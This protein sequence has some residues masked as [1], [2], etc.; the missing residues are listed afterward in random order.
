MGI[1]Y[2]EAS[3]FHDNSTVYGFCYDLV[4]DRPVRIRGRFS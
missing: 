4:S 1:E 2:T 3:I